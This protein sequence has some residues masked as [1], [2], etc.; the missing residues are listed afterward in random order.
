M[1]EVQTY[2]TPD[3]SPTTEA[4]DDYQQIDATP[5]K[6]GGLVAQALSGL[7]SSFGQAS[8]DIKG[9]IDQAQQLNNE[10]LANQG[11]T[12]F[13]LKGTDATS[14]FLSLSGQDAVN[15]FPQYQKQLTDLR[16]Q[17]LA[18]MPNPMAQAMLG[19]NLSYRYS[20]Y[21]EAGAVHAAQQSKVFS[22]QTSQ[23]AA[24]QYTSEAFQN[25][26]DPGKVGTM[27]AAGT[28]EIA[29]QGQ[30]MG[31]D[32]QSVAQ[33]Q[34]TYVGKTL[35]TVTAGLI[36]DGNIPAAQALFQQYKGSADPASAIRITQLLQPAVDDDVA[37]SVL[38]SATYNGQPNVNPTVTMPTLSDAV[39]ATESGGQQ[40]GPD[41]KVLT[42][43][44][45]AVGMMQLEPGAAQQAAQALGIPYDPAQVASNPSYNRKLGNEYLQI[46]INTFKDPTLAVAA[47]N[48]GPGAVQAALLVPGVRD[49]NTGAVNYGALLGALP[50]ETQNYVRSIA[51][52]VNL[53]SGI[54]STSPNPT[55]P[56]DEQELFA[57]VQADPR[58]QVM[59]DNQKMLTFAKVHQY[60]EDS[61]ALTSQ[62][63]AQLDETI[64]ST[65]D[66]LLSGAN[67]PI[68]TQQI[69]SLYPPGNQPGQ[70]GYLVDQLQTMQLAGKLLT[71]VKFSTPEARQAMQT[72]LVTGSGPISAALR[73]RDGLTV[74]A[75]GNV[76]PDQQAADFNLRAQVSKVLSDQMKAVDTQLKADPAAYMLQDPT[77]NADYQAYAKNPSAQTLAPYVQA[78]TAMQTRMGI[79][80]D[81]QFILPA[82]DAQAL[83]KTL[84]QTDPAKEDIG[85]V[86]DGQAKIYGAAWPQVFS[87]LVK[88]QNLPGTW[89]V[90]GAMDAPGQLAARSDMVRALQEDAKGGG[91]K[92]AIGDPNTAA[93]V[94]AAGA[95]PLMQQFSTTAA[96]PG[97]SGNSDVIANV[98]TGIQTLASYYVMQGQ[99]PA[100]AVSAASQAV[101]GAKYDF[102]GTYRVPAGTSGQADTMIADTEH[103]LKNLI[104]PNYAGATPNSDPTA[105]ARLND[106]ISVPKVW[107]TNGND[108][109]LIMAFRRQDG[110]VV[111]VY[112][113][114][115][116]PL[117][118][119]FSDMNKINPAA[120][121]APVQPGQKN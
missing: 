14:K 56:V 4:G 113:K 34:Q 102:D 58:W 55:Q 9:A 65:Q 12:N 37:A 70:A 3:V 116:N 59:N 94:K 24:D 16:N 108:D 91:L 48:A 49:P 87:Q 95:D 62:G 69:Q 23:A 104:S 43:P 92:V 74:D 106:L 25:R 64:K 72:D 111:P 66:A 13:G 19:Q 22:V 85:A 10:S 42:S 90:V 2:N 35:E 18:A 107:L 76:S 63:R 71:S 36:Q 61:A 15:A 93:I 117:G 75:S 17:T 101:L 73:Q 21:M 5:E 114:D 11:A 84:T 105:Q 110:S 31:L 53:G 96:V 98:R 119:K 32:P 121:G 44:K 26:Q 29:K 33:Q 109:G 120:L 99:T 38:K 57:K 103:N 54:G 40:F 39:M 78:T 80:P 45:G 67:V 68:P 1:A 7:G 27:I 30:I 82:P 60:A 20:S 81:Q 8:T 86:L 46:Q 52:R 115:G 83:A 88:Q 51:T 79:P 6:F 41:G 28:G 50:Q 89:Q 118:F 112:G 97:W 47:Y 77:V 100:A